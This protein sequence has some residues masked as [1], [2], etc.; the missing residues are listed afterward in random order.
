[1]CASASKFATWDEKVARVWDPADSIR[2][3]YYVWQSDYDQ[4]SITDGSKYNAQHAF[5][6]TKYMVTD[7]ERRFGPYPFLQYGQVAVQPFEYGGMEHQTITTLNRSWLRGWDEGGIAH[8]LGHQ[9]FGDN[10]TCE[11]FK[12]IWLNE[13][14]ATFCEAIYNEAW[15]GNQWYMSTIRSKADG[16][17]NGSNNTIPIYDPPEEILFNGATTYNK[18]ACVIHMLRRMV[19]NDSLFF[20]ALRAYQDHFSY[21]YC[22]TAEFR[23]FM[24]AWFAIDLS[25]FFDEWIYGQLH[26]VYDIYWAQSD[27]NEV[28]LRV[29]QTQDA[30]DHFTMP[31]NFF[32]WH[33]GTV[34]TLRFQNGARS[35]RF[36]ALVGYKIDSLLF[37]DDALLLSQHTMTY[38]AL[39]S[40]K[41][42]ATSD[43]FDVRTDGH[44][45]ILRSS[46]DGTVEIY[47]LMGKP[48]SSLP[49]TANINSWYDAS[50]LA[51]GT[52]FVRLSAGK[53]ETMK[54]I[55]IVK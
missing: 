6:N 26:P 35:E 13:G 39:L 30:R 8:E 16:Y 47:D 38:D 55:Q 28:F 37:D 31:I 23:D 2:L 9:W 15:G 20:G 46:A 34:D 21:S 49:V 1:M 45:I 17:F 40:V 10:V 53:K 50:H 54:T 22:T 32:A 18:A 27:N 14:F 33:G 29:N 51:T 41:E 11:T 52:Y 19:R 3:H 4:D 5:K 48:V 44:Q 24:S 36:A 12:D 42:N 25:D 7:F 43:Q